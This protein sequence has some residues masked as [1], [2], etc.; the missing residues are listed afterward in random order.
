LF[1]LGAASFLPSLLNY[2]WILSSWLGDLQAPIGIA[3]MIV[4]GAIWF[5]ARLRQ[6]RNASPIAG[7]TPPEENPPSDG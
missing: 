1:G 3:A 6:F 5:S 7:P 2:E 4:G